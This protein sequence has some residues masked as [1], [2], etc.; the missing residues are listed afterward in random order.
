MAYLLGGLS[1]EKAHKSS[2]IMTYSV[3]ECKYSGYV[4]ILGAYNRPG[5]PRALKMVQPLSEVHTLGGINE[6]PL[7]DMYA[8]YSHT[9]TRV[10]GEI[11]L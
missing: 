10:I 3:I 11:E 8:C 9:T 2:H 6:V 5:T 4:Y 7:R 1:D